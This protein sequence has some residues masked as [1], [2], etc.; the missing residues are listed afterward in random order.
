MRAVDLAGFHP[1]HASCCRLTRTRPP[2]SLPYP[3][4]SRLH[5]LLNVDFAFSCRGLCRNISAY[6]FQE[7]CSFKEIK[8]VP[9]WFSRSLLTVN[10]CLFLHEEQMQVQT[11]YIKQRITLFGKTSDIPVLNATLKVP[12]NF[13]HSLWYPSR[14]QCHHI[15]LK[16]HV[17]RLHNLFRVFTNTTKGK[18][19]WS[20]HWTTRSAHGKH[21][22]ALA[23]TSSLFRGRSHTELQHA[24]LTLHSGT[25]QEAS[26]SRDSWNGLS[27]LFH[28]T[29]HF[30]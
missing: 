28:K 3:I 29:T 18:N 1:H 6:L 11:I 19:I 24:S 9:C 21:G 17:R 8:N 12:H 10:D 4:L 27:Q 30:H 13:L 25:T 23:L 7:E 5:N 20:V 22:G 16:I 15:I 14:I 26:A 2:S